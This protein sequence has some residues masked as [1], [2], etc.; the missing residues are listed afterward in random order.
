MFCLIGMNHLMFWWDI[1]QEVGFGASLYRQGF[2]AC[3][4][5]Y[6]CFNNESLFV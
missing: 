1:L 3:V 4:S 2:C 6:F 5:A